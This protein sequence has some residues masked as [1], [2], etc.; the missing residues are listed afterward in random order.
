MFLK[1]RDT[2]LAAANSNSQ[3]PFYHSSDF[4]SK[5]LGERNLK[6]SVSRGRGQRFEARLASILNSR[7]L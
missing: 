4:E 1:P 7:F 5:I 2:N 6:G 3:R